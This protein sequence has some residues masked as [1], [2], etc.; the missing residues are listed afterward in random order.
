[1]LPHE[2]TSWCL[3]RYQFFS[4]V[5]SLLTFITSFC[6]KAVFMRPSPSD[7]SFPNVLAVFCPHLLHWLLM[8][9]F[10]LLLLIRLSGVLPKSWSSDVS[11]ETCLY[12]YCTALLLRLAAMIKQRSISSF[13]LVEGRLFWLVG[14]HVCAPWAILWTS[15]FFLKIH[16]MR[17]VSQRREGLVREIRGDGHVCMSLAWGEKGGFFISI[18]LN[19]VV[20]GSLWC[21]HD[22]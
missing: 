14:K 8:Y 7:H 4:S 5:L 10:R 12:S 17:R 18:Y 9:L 3:I 6:Q 11:F 1:M 16:W 19:C 21:F 13:M 20:L 2:F 15:F 22:L